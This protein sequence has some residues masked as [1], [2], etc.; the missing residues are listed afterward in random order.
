[1]AVLPPQAGG[2]SGQ[3]GAGAQGIPS[4]GTPTQFGSGA[5]RLSD[6]LQANK[7]QVQEMAN[8]VSGQMGTQFGNI[9]S[10]IGQAANQFGQQ[11]QNSYTPT[12]PTILEQVKTNPVEAAK[13]PSSVSSFQKQLNSQYSGPA[14]FESTT[15]YQSV[16]KSVQDA[17]QQANL[18]G[19]YQGL[20]GYL[21]NNVEKNA[22]PGQN[23]LDTVLLQ[24]SQPAFQTVQNAAKPF[25]GLGDYLSGITAQQNQS[26]QAAQ[27]AAPAT[28]QA[29]QQA[30][31][32]ATDP[33]IEG[34]NT[35]YQT[36]FNKSK[37]YNT[38][39]NTLAD[40]IG[41][42]NFGA[43][44]PEQQQQIG[45]NPA[46]IPLIQQYPEIF[47]TQ[48]QNNPI[49]WS[50]YF[51]QG[52]QAPTP[53]PG[54]TVTPEQLAQY[55]ALTTLGGSAPQGLNFSMPQELS[56]QFGLPAEAPQYNNVQAATAIE[57]SY[58][59]MFQ[60]L[61]KAG[62]PG[63]NGQD[64]EKIVNYMN[65]LYGFLNNPQPS[66]EPTA[67]P[68]EPTSPQP[69]PGYVWNPTLGEWQDMG[70]GGGGGGNTTT[71]PVGGGGGNTFSR[72]IG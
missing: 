17:M 21:Q 29:A 61:A 66:P 28:R 68:Q 41:N 26:V 36:A 31:Q 11:V 23:T 6:Y 60:Q 53:T 64:K 8:Q 14:N 12:D 50:N 47:A 2:S 18:L 71:P 44:T 39:L 3:A 57:Q 33:L 42:K 52:A 20:S 32:S 10:G 45:F 25:S 72:P 13:N 7:D 58:G 51:T 40:F 43:L 19:N 62:F 24:S 27:Q 4:K 34:L 65:S 48:A 55:Q 54:N 1:M 59:P 30:L 16:Q 46:L 70:G 38:G 56:D 35:G 63:V 67:P 5:S 69:G 49:N 9:Q 37:D 15:P 22:T